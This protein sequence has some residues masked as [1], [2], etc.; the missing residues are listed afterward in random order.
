MIFISPV[1]KFIISI[2]GPAVSV[3]GWGLCS[4]IRG[5]TFVVASPLYVWE[6][7]RHYRDSGNIPYLS[8]IKYD[9]RSLF[10]IISGVQN[11]ETNLVLPRGLKLIVRDVTR[12]MDKTYGTSYMIHLDTLA[13]DYYV[14]STDKGI[15]EIKDE[16][17]V[18]RHQYL[19]DV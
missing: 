15:F 2:M 10:E 19:E 1:K 4:K 14:A 16:R 3:L 5:K 6:T 12:T 18:P 7:G 17:L 9:P 8:P 13:G 11:Y